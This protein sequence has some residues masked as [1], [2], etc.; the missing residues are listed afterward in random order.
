[1]DMNE[2][3]DLF[4][5]L[6]G[7]SQLEA[8]KELHLWVAP[9]LELRFVEGLREPKPYAP[10]RLKQEIQDSVARRALALTEQHAL[11]TN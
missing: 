9:R 3:K 11:N 8:A 4:A 2:V 6:D 5:H 10:N 7:R 1:M